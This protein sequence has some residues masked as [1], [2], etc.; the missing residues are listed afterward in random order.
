MAFWSALEWANRRKKE[1]RGGR[2]SL[3]ADV[4][5]TRTFQW[6]FSPACVCVCVC[7]S[8]P[9]SYITIR[10]CHAVAQWRRY[11]RRGLYR[12]RQKVSGDVR[13]CL[14]GT[15]TENCFVVICKQGLFCRILFGFEKICSLVFVRVHA[16]VCRK[17]FLLLLLFCSFCVKG[18]AL[19]E[20]VMW[21]SGRLKIV[22]LNAAI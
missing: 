13:V 21:S 18:F 3:S 10:P 17:P 11:G 5:P 20:Y 4:T 15:E 14:W 2:H 12:W 8:M 6:P 19:S 22:L 16:Y 1:P 7:A 9:E